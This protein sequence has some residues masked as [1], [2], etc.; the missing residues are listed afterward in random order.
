MSKGQFG[1]SYQQVARTEPMT[2]AAE[3]QWQLLPPLT[4]ST[5]RIV[6]TGRY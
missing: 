2:M 4:F 6:I 5:D 1:D 3:M